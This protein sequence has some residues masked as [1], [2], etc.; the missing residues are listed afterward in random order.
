MYGVDTLYEWRWLD[1]DNVPNDE[2]ENVR[3][4]GI[5]RVQKAMSKAFGGELMV[6][7]K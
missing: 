6:Q 2:E 4:R 5:N 7:R 1:N 3:C